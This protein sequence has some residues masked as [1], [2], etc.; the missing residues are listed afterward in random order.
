MDYVHGFVALN[1]SACCLEFSKALL[2]VHAA[3]DRSVILLQL[4]TT[5][6]QGSFG[7]KR[8]SKTHRNLIKRV[9]VRCGLA[10]EHLRQDAIEE[11]D[12]FALPIW[13][14]RQTRLLDLRDNK[15]CRDGARSARQ[16]CDR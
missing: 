1:G 16:W 3:F 11:T 2:G 14:R 10:A 4:A 5:V 13:R 9:V 12:S 6:G 8:F 7:R 15:M